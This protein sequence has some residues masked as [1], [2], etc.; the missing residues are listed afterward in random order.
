[1]QRKKILCTYI[2][3][4]KCMRCKYVKNIINCIV[5]LIHFWHKNSHSYNSQLLHLLKQICIHK[6][7][8]KKCY[9]YLIIDDMTGDTRHD[10]MEENIEMAFMID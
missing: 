4:L 3:F 5:K 1:M 6:W 7:R 10:K 8:I 9:L 2:I